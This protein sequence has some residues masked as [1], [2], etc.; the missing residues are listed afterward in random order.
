MAQRALSTGF[1]VAVAADGRSA[2]G[3]SQ[4]LA[5]GAVA[6]V[7]ETPVDVVAVCVPRPSDVRGVAERRPRSAT[8]FVDLSTGSPDESRS[9]AQSLALEGVTY[10]DAPVSGSIAGARDGDLTTWVGA[11]SLDTSPALLIAALAER[12][13]MMGEPGRGNAA[14]LVN[15]V[16][17]ISNMAV[18]GEGLEV[19]RRLGL[20]ESTMVDSLKHASADSAM[21]RRFGD[22]IV[23]GDFSPRFA[24]AFALKD[25][26]AALA[27]A[28]CD[29]DP[30]PIVKVVRERLSRLSDDPDAAALDFS[31]I[32]SPSGVRSDMVP[33]RQQS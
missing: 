16:M 21:L 13:Y 1:V 27:S 10:V 2:E 9:L 30:L 8:T 18:I 25:I 22:S 24:L 15:Q 3:T 7:P 23:S 29:D 6:L 19:A 32:A 33:E 17:H 5:E 20:D 14:K 4:L 26:N 12:V 28:G 31:L 11:S